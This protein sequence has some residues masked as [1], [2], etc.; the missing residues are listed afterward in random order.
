[1]K[2]LPSF[3]YWEELRI[4]VKGASKMLKQRSELVSRTPA[5]RGS[6]VRMVSQVH[7]L[8]VDTCINSCS[9]FMA[10]R[11]KSDICDECQTSR[12]ESA[13]SPRQKVTHWPTIHWLVSFVA[14]SATVDAHDGDGSTKP[15]Q[16]LP[17]VCAWH[18]GT[19]FCLLS[20][21][22]ATSQQAPRE[23]PVVQRTVSRFGVRTASRHGVL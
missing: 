2:D 17:R 1:M 8:A 20:Q 18:H 4:T 19:V 10:L 5:S 7:T 22:E 23:R 12:R 11:A 16:N 21:Q 15:T 9:T 6:L 13:G 3:I 14:S